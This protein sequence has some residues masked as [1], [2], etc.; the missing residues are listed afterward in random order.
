MREIGE[1][2]LNEYLSMQVG[3]RRKILVEKNGVGRTE[4][5]A[6]TEIGIGEPG[7]IITADIV[8]YIPGRLL[9][10]GLLMEQ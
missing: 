7:E 8:G 4:Q 2:K 3:Q 9:G 6:Q 10:D 5:F 1:T